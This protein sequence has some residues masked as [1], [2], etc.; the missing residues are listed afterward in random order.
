M[1]RPAEFWHGTHVALNPGDIISPR[2]SRGGQS[3]FETTDSSKD[4]TGWNPGHVA[5]ATDS[6]E[7]AEWYAQHAAKKHGEGRVY[8]V[9]PVNPSDLE[10]DKYGGGFDKPAYQS[11]SGFRVV[12]EH[13]SGV[14][15]KCYTL[16]NTEGKCTCP[17]NS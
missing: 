15:R 4:L 17:D 16:R 8:K 12:S 14:C 7:I 1:S 6:V 5:Y 3:N 10:E 13:R 9:E 11:P 2:N